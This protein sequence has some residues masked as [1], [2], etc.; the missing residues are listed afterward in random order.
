MLAAVAH[1]FRWE[2]LRFLTAQ[3]VLPLSAL[4]GM[5]TARI[6]FDTIAILGQWVQILVSC[7]LV[8]AFAG[9]VPLL[10]KLESTPLRNLI[11]LLPF[12][13]AIFGMN[14]LRLECGLIASSHGVPWIFA[15]D[16]PLGFAYFMIWVYVWQAR[17]WRAWQSR[18]PGERIEA[19]HLLSP[20]R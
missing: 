6:S 14:I 8:E 15:H 4:L 5:T 3:A 17:S 9:S 12:A 16:I 7:T 20:T 2:W 11:R 13:S 19:S 10:W 1:Q 18:L